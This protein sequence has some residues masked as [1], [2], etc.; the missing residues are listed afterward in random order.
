M[1]NENRREFVPS[2]MNDI[3]TKVKKKLNFS[4]VDNFYLLEWTTSESRWAWQWAWRCSPWS[5]S[6]SPEW[7]RPSDSEWRWT[8]CCGWTLEPNSRW[9]NHNL[10]NKIF[11][12][13]E[14]DYLATEHYQVSCV[15]KFDLHERH[16]F[17]GTTARCRGN[18]QFEIKFVAGRLFWRHTAL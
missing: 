14:L 10:K 11:F 2:W 12:T 13:Y 5:F 3:L 8:L 15:N 6:R 18:F 9:C 17:E 4:I 16:I 1:K 7:C